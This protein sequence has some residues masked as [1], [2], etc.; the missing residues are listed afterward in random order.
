[1]CI[2]WVLWQVVFFFSVETLSRWGG[3]GSD[4]FCFT[5]YQNRVLILS[6]VG[7][8]RCIGV[9]YMFSFVDV[10]V[11]LGVEFSNDN[12]WLWFHWGGIRY[13][14][15]ADDTLMFA[16]LLVVLFE[17]LSYSYL[18]LFYVRYV[19]SFVVVVGISII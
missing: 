11:C 8:F 16:V 10:C 19:F 17:E 6:Q 18:S 1:M 15:F 4:S 12:T 7:S 14:N 13:P 5:H 3:V 9:S 2:D